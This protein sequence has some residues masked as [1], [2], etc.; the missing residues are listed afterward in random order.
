VR[1]LRRSNRIGYRPGPWQRV[2][3]RRRAN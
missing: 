1:H 2:C 3:R